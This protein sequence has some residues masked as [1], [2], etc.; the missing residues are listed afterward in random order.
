MPYDAQVRWGGR[1]RRGRSAA[2][3]SGSADVVHGTAL[4]SLNGKVKSKYGF[5]LWMIQMLDALLDARSVTATTNHFARSV[6]IAAAAQSAGDFGGT[7]SRARRSV[8]GEAS[9]VRR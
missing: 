8:P 2:A 6:L 3:V 4:E 9:N 5:Q 1:V 7:F